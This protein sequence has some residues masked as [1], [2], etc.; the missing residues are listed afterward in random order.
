MPGAKKSTWIG[1]TIFVSFVIIAVAWF[2]AIS[3][4]LASASDSS[5]QTETTRQ[6]NEILRVNIIKLQADFAK[7]PDYKAQLAAIRVQ[8]PTD[9]GLSAYFRELAD[10]ATADSVTITAIAPKEPLS[11]VS[12]APVA[13]SAPAPATPADATPAAAPAATPAATGKAGAGSAGFAAIP[14]SITVVGSYDNT[15]KFMSDVQA[16][17]TRLFLVAGVKGTAKDVAPKGNGLPATVLG[18]QELVITGFAY[19]LADPYAVPVPVDPAAKA[20]A[21]PGAVPGKNPLMPYGGAK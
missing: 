20:P 1:G 15:V 8:I 13:Q 21:L 2:L 14:V 7:L 9:A 16:S 6:Q 12:A 5:Q 17:P 18:D 4:T 3:P 19:V 11:V 10:I